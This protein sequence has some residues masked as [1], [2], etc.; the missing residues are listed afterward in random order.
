MQLATKRVMRSEHWGWGEQMM[1]TDQ[2]MRAG[3]TAVAAVP[4]SMRRATRR[5]F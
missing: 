3:M 2:I 5:V 4:A 1:M